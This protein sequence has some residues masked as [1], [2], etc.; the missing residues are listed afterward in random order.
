MALIS[1]LLHPS[2]AATIHLIRAAQAWPHDPEPWS[3]PPFS[4]DVVHCWS[5]HGFSHD[6]SIKKE[7]GQCEDE[8]HHAIKLPCHG[9]ETDIGHGSNLLDALHCSERHAVWGSLA[10]SPSESATPETTL[11][12]GSLRAAILDQSFSPTPAVHPQ[13]LP[14]S[15]FRGYSEMSSP[16]CDALRRLH[17]MALG[18]RHTGH[19]FSA[20][21]FPRFLKHEH[22]AI[23]YVPNVSDVIPP[24]PP[25]ES[26]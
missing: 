20:M 12:H 2:S 18:R 26:S 15:R 13:V 23:L 19:G 21:Q 16:G 6:R 22:F 9:C 25:S 10:G 14:R 24:P 4:F 1:R 5:G 7:L 3:S 11:C 8:Y 17:E